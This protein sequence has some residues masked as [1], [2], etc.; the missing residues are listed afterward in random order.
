M[1]KCIKYKFGG[2]L[3][4]FLCI[5]TWATT[6]ASK[7]KRSDNDARPTSNHHQPKDQTMISTISMQLEQPRRPQPIPTQ[8]RAS[9]TSKHR[10]NYKNSKKLSFLSCAAIMLKPASA[11]ISNMS[12]RS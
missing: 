6:I 8:R 12:T 10:V 7:R 5:S 1:T 9:S 4:Q 3:Y 2:I 11:T